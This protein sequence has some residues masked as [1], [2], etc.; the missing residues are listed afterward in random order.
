MDFQTFKKAVIAKAESLEIAE[1]E[2]YYQA[3]ESTSV[4]AFQHEMNEFSAANEGGVCFRCIVNGKM[5]YAST[6]SLCME[7]AEAIVQ[8]AKENALVLEAEEPVFLCQGGKTYQKLKLT[9]YDLPS[10]EALV[11][12]VLST[13]E[14]LYNADSA[15]A[16]GSSTQ[17]ISA[18]SR[19]AIVNSKGLDLQYENNLAG[20]VTGAVVS[21]G[22][23]MANDYQIK[24]GKLDTLDTDALA[25]KA[26][27][28][29]LRKLGGEV[30][31]TG[32]CPVVFDPEAMSDLLSTYSGIFSAE[33]AQ[34]G[35]SK[36]SDK[37]GQMIASPAVTLVDDPF[38]PDS[39][40]PIHF[41]AEGYPTATKKVIEAGRL[42][43]LLYNLKT[44]AVAEKEST[45]NASKAK[46]SSSV[47]VRPFTMYLAGGEMTEEELLQKAGNGV[48]I[49]S[50]GGLHAGADPI[51]G[52][53]SLQSA[54]FLIENGVKTKAV[55]SF[56]VAGNFYELLQNI[57]AVANNTQLPAALGM[58]AFGAPSVLV[59]KL[60]IA[61]K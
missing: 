25:K 24:L 53:F 14:K 23:E 15:V 54:G 57:V 49:N 45:G 37:E 60:S 3:E 17:G 40:M 7:E 36:L 55:K 61:G 35:L 42:N 29:A 27:E 2:L 30:A 38:H 28:G 1:Y 4:S 47:T 59:E 41:D 10:T 12:A 50:L 43:T 48:Y 39:P 34:K 44:A 31:P 22:K 5:G 13:Q 52:D 33:A 20:L 8:R 32:V 46:Y 26:V 16:D 58:T 56:T 51:S 19:I 6:E 18:C 21:D 11:A 9:P